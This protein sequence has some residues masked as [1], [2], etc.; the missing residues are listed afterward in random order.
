MMTRA[1]RLLPREAYD[2]LEHK[3]TLH[4][5]CGQPE[6]KEIND[7]GADIRVRITVT[8]SQDMTVC[9]DNT[10]LDQTNGTSSE[11]AA[12]PNVRRSPV[13]P[14]R[15]RGEPIVIYNNKIMCGIC[16]EKI[17]RDEDRGHV[18]SDGCNCNFDYYYKCLLRMQ[19]EN[20]L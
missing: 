2:A 20:V 12:I 14:L 1:E 3:C 18:I 11:T 13:F 10:A 7:K 5:N 17:V 16:N 15:R 19:N 8:G 9:Q 4:F 6:D